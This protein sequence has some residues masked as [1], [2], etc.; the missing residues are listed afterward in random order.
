MVTPADTLPSS[1]ESLFNE[2]GAIELQTLNTGGVQVA[3]DR[4][5]NLENTS[6]RTLYQRTGAASEQ[7]DLTVFSH[8]I[9]HPRRGD[10]LIDTGFDS[11]FT[12]K[13]WGNITGLLVMASSSTSQQAKQDIGS[14]IKALG[15]RPQGV[16]FTH[17]HGDHTAG[18]PALPVT[19]KYVIGK[20]E[21]YHDIPL[22]YSHGHLSKS[23]TLFEIDFEKAKTMPILGKTVDVWGDHSL[24]AIDTRGHSK[25]HMSFLIN[26]TE[27]WVLLTGDASHTRWGFENNIEPGLADDRELARKS[28]EKLV[29]FS[30][31]YPFVRVIFGHEL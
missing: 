9:A 28:F 25:G 24:L 19:T 12:E 4:M 8:W 1:W 17:L 31:A 21:E 30:K 23:T 29:D 14:Q 6:A 13:S 2:K 26:T 16:F 27:G 5:L 20:N 15:I 10:F 3:A 18:A 22:I 7:L 11:S